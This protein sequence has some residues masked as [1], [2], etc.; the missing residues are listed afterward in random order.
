MMSFENIP[1]EINTILGGESKDFIVKAGR[2]FPLKA[3]LPLLIFGLVWLGFSSVFVALLL[4]PIFA[5]K[6]LHITI[7]HV[8]T[9]I[10]PGNLK[11]LMFPLSMMSIF[12]FIGLGMVIYGIYSLIA[13]GGWFIGTPKR[14]ISYQ[15]NRVR[16][17]DW[18]QFS[19]DI[20]ISGS[21]EKGNISLQMR[22]GRMVSRKNSGTQYVPD[23]IYICGIPSA[24]AVEQICRK[25][26]KENDPTPANVEN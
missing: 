7:N 11:P 19:G 1:Q 15:K 2:K 4:G 22:T 13:K 18:E 20:E 26:I 17:V 8:P 6:E 9:V 21:N 12:I 14:L 5:G 16:S 25:R 24:F 10:S 3:S 23:V